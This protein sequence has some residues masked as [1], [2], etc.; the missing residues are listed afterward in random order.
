MRLEWS[1]SITGNHNNKKNGNNTDNNVMRAQRKRERGSFLVYCTVI[2]LSSPA[3]RS[4]PINRQTFINQLALINGSTDRKPTALYLRLTSHAYTYTT[5]I[6]NEKRKRG[7]TNEIVERE[8]D[9]SLGVREKEILVEAVN[10]EPYRTHQPHQ[11][12]QQPKKTEKPPMVASVIIA[13]N[14]LTFTLYYIYIY[15]IYTPMQLIIA[16]D[17]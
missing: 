4:A 5:T 14:T 7:E 3:Q 13:R 2:R 11:V 1:T 6:I 8:R 16:T 10:A 9:T 17:Y 12:T 15:Q